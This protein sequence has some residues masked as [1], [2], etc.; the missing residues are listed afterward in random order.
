MILTAELDLSSRSIID[1]CQ[2]SRSEV[3]TFDWH[4]HTHTH[5]HKCTTWTTKVVRKYLSAKVLSHL[6]K[7]WNCDSHLT[8]KVQ[9]ASLSGVAAW[10]SW[11]YQRSCSTSGPVS[12]GMGDRFADIPSLYVIRHPGQLSLLPSVR[13]EMTTGR[14][15]VV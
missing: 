3:I 10:C 1:A 15:A 5:T 13:W 7:G 2:L 9:R 14:R 4:T 12:A 8:S 6:L 11:T